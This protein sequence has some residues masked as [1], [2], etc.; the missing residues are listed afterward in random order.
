MLVSVFAFAQKPVK[1]GVYVGGATPFGDMGNGEVKKTTMYPLGDI[2]KWALQYEDGTDGY[3]GIGFDLGFD[4]TIAMP[5]EGLGIFGGIDFFFNSNKSSLNDCLDDYARNAVKD[6][7]F[8]SEITY[9]KAHFM[10]VPILFGVNY[11]HDFN[12][13]VGIWGEA[14]FGPN[15]RFIDNYE[16][17]TTYNTAM[18]TVFP[19]GE[20]VTYIEETV[21]AKYKTAVTFAFKIGGGVMLWDKMS[22]GLDFY[23]LG[24]AKIEAT[25]I[26]K[27]GSTDYADR[28]YVNKTSTGK[29]AISASELTVRVG[30]HF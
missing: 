7:P 4:V 5:V 26:H 13:I 12:N 1:F 24:S 30:Y 22:I 19:N 28:F 11:L 20:S 21:G 27:L 29:N 18:T 17:K 16:Q 6:N 25:G 15:F 10:N 8:V 23:Y 9:N 3:A 14:G 2:T